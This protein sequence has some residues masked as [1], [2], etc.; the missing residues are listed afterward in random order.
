MD[1]GIPP[2]NC[3]S[4]ASTVSISEE[5]LRFKGGKYK[6]LL[7]FTSL[8]LFRQ[9]KG[10]KKPTKEGTLHKAISCGAIATGNRLF[11]DS[12]RGAPPLLC[13]TPPNQATP[14][15]MYTKGENVPIFAHPSSD[16]FHFKQKRRDTFCLNGRYSKMLRSGQVRTGDS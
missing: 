14:E 10:E 5:S 1:H 12:L 11:L 8:F 9:E 13:T 4:C 7:R 15:N 6:V 2:F 16:I 3:I